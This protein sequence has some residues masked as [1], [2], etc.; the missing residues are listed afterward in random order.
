[1]WGELVAK[2]VCV[3]RYYW[4]YAG[5]FA[6]FALF[7]LSVHAVGFAFEGGRKATANFRFDRIDD[8]SLGLWDGDRPVMVY[9]FGVR[10]KPGVAEDRQ[11]SS[12][13]HPLYGL[14]GEV[15]TDDFPAD[16]LHH[17]GLF[18]AWPHVRVGN[19]EHDLWALRGI[20][21]QFERWTEKKTNS[22][23]AVLGIEN[24][25]YI[26]D[27]RV[28]RENVHFVV[29]AATENERAIDIDFE[30]TALGEPV[31]LS[32]AAGKSYGGLSLR[33]A[34]R[35]ETAVTTDEGLQPKDLNLTRL[36]WADLTARFENTPRPSGV[37]ILVDR[38]HPGFPPT[39]ITRHYGFLGVG[40]PGVEPRTFE[41][42]D[43][44]TC[45]YR[46]V[47]H[48]GVADP[49]RL[50]R[51]YEEFCSSPPVSKG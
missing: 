38:R 10:T 16:H 6:L 5:L 28:M 9:N 39:W 24:G 29:Y 30:W 26:A 19:Q 47:I 40:W 1:M 31:T 49:A 18:W 37:A 8:G 25:W 22:T 17:R 27:R 46:I 23:N 44:V 7:A 34:P 20:R 21:Q 33:F 45:R 3:R 13:V 36:A 12:Y 14:D 42:G 32:G 41:P 50:R 15:L 51:A 35:Q 43:P 11:R 48:R 2:D 4:H